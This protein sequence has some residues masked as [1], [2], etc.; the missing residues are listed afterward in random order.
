MLFLSIYAKSQIIFLNNP[1]NHAVAF[2]PAFSS[3]QPY[4]NV[5][6]ISNQAGVS[7]R[8]SKQQQDVLS[9]AQYFFTKKNIG[10]SAHYNFVNQSKNTF[11]KAGLGLSYQLL[12][13]NTVS[14]GWGISVNYNQ[15]MADSAAVYTLYNDT[16]RYG[17]NKSNY[18]S[19]NFGG[20]INYDR[21]MLGFSLQP[22]QCVFLN[23][24]QKGSYYTTGS[25]YIK[26][27]YPISRNKSATIWYNANWNT[28]QNL[29][30]MQTIVTK[31]QLQSHAL[32]IHISGKKGI[33]GGVGC[34]ITDFNYTSAIVKIGYNVKHWQLTYGVE[35][36]WLHK[37]YSEIIHELSFTFK[38]Y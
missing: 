24:N 28:F 14:T 9:S 11:Q 17:L 22:N 13:F 29:I 2:N 16:K 18:V 27:R 3:I 12:F 31:Q 32:H 37:K 35:P 23:S 26:Y 5:N 21:L 34:R 1:S 25:A 10:L 7:S 33:I 8:F 6:Y 15:L 38:F 36:Y 19:L 20:L 30:Y 4:F